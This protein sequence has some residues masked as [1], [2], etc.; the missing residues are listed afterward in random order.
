MSLHLP[1]V[2]SR[3]SYRYPFILVD[4]VTEYEPGGRLVACKNV[5]VSEEFFQG[6]FPGSPL[7]PGVLMIEALTQAAAALVLGREGAPPNARAAL[8][9][10]DNAK[11]RRQVVPGDRLRLEVKLGPTRSRLA[12][13]HA[14]AYVDGQVAA[15]AELLLAIEPGP[16]FI[17]PS[18][19][20][21]AAAQIGEG[22]A[23]GPHAVIGGPD[24]G[25]LG[26]GYL[27][28]SYANSTENIRKALDRMGEF[29]SSRKA[30]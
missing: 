18:A 26:E 25:V 3:V 7:M 6:H 8:R 20:V 27:R 22:T 1:S 23:I 30:A 29:L 9:G 5:T 28:L 2:L 19:R 4:A 10:V 14:A 17:D 11:F 16:A 24:F 21:D 15:E 13:A 12:K